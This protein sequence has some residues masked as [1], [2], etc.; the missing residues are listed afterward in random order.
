MLLREIDIPDELRRVQP[1][2]RQDRIAGVRSIGPPE[3][4]RAT[5]PVR[6]P[7]HSALRYI[8]R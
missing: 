4:R 5:K 8:A 1:R 3:R 2:A 6:Q 7:A